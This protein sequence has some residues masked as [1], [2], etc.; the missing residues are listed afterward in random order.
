M[1]AVNEGCKLVAQA[2]EL[3]LKLAHDNRRLDDESHINLR[4][5][6]IL[7]DNALEKLAV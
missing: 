4:D 1:E 2:K 3:I 5:A 6:I 7:L